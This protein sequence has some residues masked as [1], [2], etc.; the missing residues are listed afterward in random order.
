MAMRGIVYSLLAISLIIPLLLYAIFNLE[1]KSIDKERTTQRILNDRLSSYINSVFFDLP[2]AAE[3][4]VKKALVAAVFFVES[5]NNPLDNAE[6]RLKEL[7]LNKSL[8]GTPSSLMNESI[9]DWIQK[10]QERG[11]VYGFFTNISIASLDLF[12][13]DSFTIVFSINLS[14]N[15]SN[16]LDTN[17]S[18]LLNYLLNVSIEG[19]EDPLYPLNT[20]GF[21]VRFIKKANSTVYGVTGVDSAI[22]NGWYLST[23]EGP[24]FLDR[25]E[26]KLYLSQRYLNK[27]ITSIN[28][29]GLESFVDLTELSSKNIPIK[30]NQSIVDHYY[31][32]NTL[33]KGYLVNHSIFSWNRLDDYHA[34]V[35][36]VSAYLIK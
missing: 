23:N 32:N 30:E 1:Y 7:I 5:T 28:S 36:G 6:L 19:F 2:R 24:S 16:G 17:V 9:Y 8:Y 14:V 35:Y 31:F 11:R 33:I 3:S 18:R 12:F 34:S 21:V 22:S 20:N 27:N 29:I 4:S 10:V 26:G 25:L 15:I 13:Y